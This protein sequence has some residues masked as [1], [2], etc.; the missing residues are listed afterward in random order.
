MTWN[1]IFLKILSYSN[2]PCSL[3]NIV[4]NFVW[5]YG[6]RDNECVGLFFVSLKLHYNYMCS[7]PN[8]G[9]KGQK[10]Q[11]CHVDF[12]GHDKTKL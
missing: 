12:L 11:M 1:G 10:A 7:Q 5:A 3:A 4:G 8:V 9:L 2:E 6:C